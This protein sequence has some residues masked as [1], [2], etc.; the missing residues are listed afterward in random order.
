MEI[1]RLPFSGD[2]TPAYGAELLAG[3][4]LPGK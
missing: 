1:Q 3:L 4:H 2:T